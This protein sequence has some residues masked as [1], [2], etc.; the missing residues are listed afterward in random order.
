ML[1]FMEAATE[2]DSTARRIQIDGI[3][4]AA[5]TGTAEVFDPET[6]SYS[7]THFIASTL[8]MV[9]ADK[10]DLIIYLTINYPRGESIY[11]GRIAAPAADELLEFLVPYRGIPRLS[12]TVTEHPGR[13]TVTREQLPPL[14]TTVPDYTGL[15]LRTVLPL[16][17]RDDVR[18][19]VNGSGWVVRQEPPPGSPVTEG[20]IIELGLE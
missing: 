5:K 4:V 15:S 1:R 7:D 13:V 6:G 10:P 12:D 11:G 20:L 18:V 14:T 3:S 9:P 2:P 16:L 8:A 19:I 17:Q